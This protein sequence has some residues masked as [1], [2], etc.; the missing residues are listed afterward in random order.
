MLGCSLAVNDRKSIIRRCSVCSPSL[1]TYRM[2]ATNVV[3]VGLG[4]EE[5]SNGRKTSDLLRT[6]AFQTP[7][8]RR[9]RQPWRLSAAPWKPPFRKRWG[10]PRPWWTF[11]CGRISSPTPYRQARRG[12][13]LQQERRTV[14]WPGATLI[15]RCVCVR[16]RGGGGGGRE[17]K[18]L[19]CSGM[20]VAGVK[21]KLLT[22]PK[23][24]AE[25]D[26]E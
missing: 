24:L 23:A 4:L 15:P 11:L 19:K 12:W 8:F 10:C 9:R 21:G 17:G 7:N 3:R 13:R 26:D 5:K 18:R 22:K 25:S 20:S 2:R 14:W 6:I 16:E 1:T